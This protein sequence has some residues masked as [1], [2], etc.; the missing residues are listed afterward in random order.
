MRTV[1]T[2]GATRRIGKFVMN[3]LSAI[4]AT[5]FAIGAKLASEIRANRD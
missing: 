5:G 4:I 1:T 3:Y 2:S